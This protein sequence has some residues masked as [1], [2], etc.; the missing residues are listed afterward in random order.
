MLNA[1]AEGSP[2][3]RAVPSRQRKNSG[4]VLLNKAESS[5]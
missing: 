3:L 2:K 4:A 5:R 1:K